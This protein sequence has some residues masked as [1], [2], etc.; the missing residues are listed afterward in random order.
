MD[1]V[2]NQ[3][4]VRHKIV[5]AIFTGKD[6]E[7]RNVNLIFGFGTSCHSMWGNLGSEIRVPVI[8]YFLSKGFY[9]TVIPKRAHLEDQTRA[10]LTKTVKFQFQL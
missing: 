3:F 1:E 7:L 6:S 8:P 4:N 9:S 10:L 5:Y 2:K